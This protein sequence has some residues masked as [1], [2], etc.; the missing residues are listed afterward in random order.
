MLCANLI[1]RNA[2]V[3]ACVFV[4]FSV[5]LLTSFRNSYGFYGR[6]TLQSTHSI[7]D[8]DEGTQQFFLSFILSLRLTV[9]LTLT[10]TFLNISTLRF[11]LNF[12]DFSI[13]LKIKRNFTLFE[14]GEKFSI[15]S[16]SIE[17]FVDFYLKI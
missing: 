7:D 1:V 2:N 15:W 17:K 10:R 11:W 5:F 3:C 9:V 16:D 12:N 14:N 13:L 6:P 8:L 4:F